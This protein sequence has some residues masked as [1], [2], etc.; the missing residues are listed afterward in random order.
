MDEFKEA[1]ILKNKKDL[2][3]FADRYPY[4]R[5]IPKPSEYPCAAK[6][7]YNDGGGHCD[8]WYTM[9]LEYPKRKRGAISFLEGVVTGWSQ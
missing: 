9:T 2:K 3:A 8:S 7:E 4:L 6:V 1:R 5:E